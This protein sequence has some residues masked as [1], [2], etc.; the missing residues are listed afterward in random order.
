VNGTDGAVAENPAP[1][2]DI[3]VIVIVP[4]PELEIVRLLVTVVPTLPVNVGKGFGV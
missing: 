1:V 3:S 4:P 2:Y